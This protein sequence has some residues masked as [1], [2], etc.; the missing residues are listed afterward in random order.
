MGRNNKNLFVCLFVYFTILEGRC[1]KSGH[2]RA[3]LLLEDAGEGLFF[4]TAGFERLSAFLDV[5]ASLDVHLHL[6]VACP[7]CLNLSLCVSSKTLVV[8]FRAYSGDPG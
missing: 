5:A 7:V 3:G 6:H 4:A 1:P 8:G 2:C